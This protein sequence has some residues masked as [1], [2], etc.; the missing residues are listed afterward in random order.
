MTRTGTGLWPCAV[1]M[2]CAALAFLRLLFSLYNT[3]Q[4]H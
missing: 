4:H 3:V 2:P 1:Q